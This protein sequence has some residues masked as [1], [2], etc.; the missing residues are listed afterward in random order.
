MLCVH[1]F[2]WQL[3]SQFDGSS[4][5]AELKRIGMDNIYFVFLN[6]FGNNF[7]TV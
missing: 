5:K 7:Y 1:N 2:I 6:K 3:F 4:H